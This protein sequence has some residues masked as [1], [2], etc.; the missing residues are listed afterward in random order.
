MPTYL[1]IDSVEEV[2]SGSQPL[3]KGRTLQCKKPSKA[4]DVFVNMHRLST[5]VVDCSGRRAVET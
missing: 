5:D 3:T 2:V 4:T 1:V